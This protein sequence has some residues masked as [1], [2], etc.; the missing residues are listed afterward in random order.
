MDT[1]RAKL[2]ALAGAGEG[3][4]HFSKVSGVQAVKEAKQQLNARLAARGAALRFPSLLRGCNLAFF[5]ASA[6]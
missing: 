5:A 1:G 6:C 2:Q 3:F 4:E